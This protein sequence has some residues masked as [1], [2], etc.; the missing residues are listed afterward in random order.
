MKFKK[1]G[2]DCVPVET[3]NDMWLSTGGGDYS[4]SEIIEKAKQKWPNVSLDDISITAV[5]HH[6]YSTGYDMH[7]SGDYVEYLYVSIN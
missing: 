3:E 4:L 7:D 2:N 6:Q 1:E 5:N